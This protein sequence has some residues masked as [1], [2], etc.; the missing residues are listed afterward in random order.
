MPSTDESLK[1]TAASRGPVRKGVGRRAHSARMEFNEVILSAAPYDRMVIVPVGRRRESTEQSS[2]KSHAEPA[3]QWANVFGHQ[4][5]CKIVQAEG[6]V[7]LQGCSACRALAVIGA[8]ARIS[9]NR[10]GRA[11]R[12]RGRDD[13]LGL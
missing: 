2:D 4:D 3:R 12:V 6:G 1:A 13:R 10:S 7:M 8:M 11:A 9:W 5:E